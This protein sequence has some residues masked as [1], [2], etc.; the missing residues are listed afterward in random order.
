[1]D[2]SEERVEQ[3]RKGVKDGILQGDELE[4]AKKLRP[5]WYTCPD[6]CP[7]PERGA[8]ILCDHHPWIVQERSE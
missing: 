8:C 3:L 1:M 2:V 7:T 6:P 4:R 5:L